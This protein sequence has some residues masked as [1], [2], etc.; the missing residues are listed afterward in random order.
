MDVLARKP[1]V[2]RCTVN[3]S[4]LV[5]CVLQNALVMAA[6]ITPN[7]KRFSRRL[8]AVIRV[9]PC[10]TTDSITK[11]ATAKKQNVKKSTAN[12]ITQD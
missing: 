11:V 2:L 10:I 7:I 3:A 1:V 12:A 8:S 5:K 4:Q 9:K 6:I